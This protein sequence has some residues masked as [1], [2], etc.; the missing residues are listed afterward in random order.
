MA[1]RITKERLEEFREA[2]EKEARKYY[3]PHRF[4]D[5]PAWFDACVRM[6]QRALLAESQLLAYHDSGA[7]G[8]LRRIEGEH[9]EDRTLSRETAALVAGTIIK[10]EAIGE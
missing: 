10:L 7:L 9:L 8:I 3:E 4:G 1:E 6:A 5:A 2:A